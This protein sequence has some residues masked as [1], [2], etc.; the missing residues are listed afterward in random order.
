M[1]AALTTAAAL[2]CGQTTH[3]TIALWALDR[4]DDPELAA[5]V[6]DP[7]PGQEQADLVAVAGLVEVVET[8][9][10]DASTRG[11]GRAT[12]ARRGTRR[13]GSPG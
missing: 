11:A 6:R 12:I 10:V 13:N 7:E 9:Q 5:L 8:E 1:L 3:V 2:A 4:V